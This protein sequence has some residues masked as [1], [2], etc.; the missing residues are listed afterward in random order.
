MEFYYG[1]IMNVEEMIDSSLNDWFSEYKY[2]NVQNIAR[3]GT[4][5]R[6]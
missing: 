3:Y 6:G 4:Q 5:S 1:N 2:A